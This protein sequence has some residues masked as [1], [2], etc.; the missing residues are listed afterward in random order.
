MSYETL[1]ALREGAPCC[2]T[3]D[4]ADS[5]DASIDAG[6]PEGGRATEGRKRIFRTPTRDLHERLLAILQEREPTSEDS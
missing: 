3:L 4:R 5:L 6:S 2:S 1:Q